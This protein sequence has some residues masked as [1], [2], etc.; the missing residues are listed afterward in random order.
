MRRRP[1]NYLQGTPRVPTPAAAITVGAHL[2]LPCEAGEVDAKRTQGA[3][4]TPRSA[5]VIRNRDGRC[6]WSPLRHGLR[7]RHLPRFAEGGRRRIFPRLSRLA[8]YRLVPSH[9]EGSWYRPRSRRRAV[10]ERGCACRSGRSQVR[11]GPRAGELKTRLSGCVGH[12]PSPP[13]EGSVHRVENARNGPPWSE[14][15]AERQSSRRNVFGAFHP[16]SLRAQARRSASLPILPAGVS[17]AGA[18]PWAQ[19]AAVVP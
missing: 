3:P 19:A 4:H 11:G 12:A 14:D 10:V 7:P 8:H 16:R 6:L 13:A 15:R 2:F 1:S 17:R 5:L 9:G 18:N